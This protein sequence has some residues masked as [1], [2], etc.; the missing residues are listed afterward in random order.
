MARCTTFS[1][2]HWPRGKATGCSTS[3]ARF[4]GVQYPPLL[5]AVV[6]VH[7]LVLGTS[8]PTTVGRWLRLSSFLIFVLYGLVALWFLR[9]YLPP[10]RA[11]LATL[12]SVFCRHAWFL[13]DAL[14]PEV[15]FGVTT[16]LF[17]IFARGAG[18]RARGIVAYVW[19]LASYAL[20][21]VGIAAF[22]VWVL[23]SLIR[24]RFREAA[25]RA[26]L[27]LLPVAGW[28]GYVAS[29]ERS[30]V[31]TRPTYAYQ[32]AP[33]LF[34][35]VSYARNVVLR[36]PFTPEKGKVQLPR[37]IVRNALDLPVHFGETL[38]ASPGYFQM[39]LHWAFGD[40]PM[41]N[42]LIDWGVFALLSA[43]GGVLVTGGVLLLLIRRQPLVPLYVLVYTAAM[44]LTPFPGQ[45]ARYLMPIAPLL[46]LLAIV[47]LDAAASWRRPPARE[48][49]AG[50]P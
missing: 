16:L 34:Y 20:R 49:G 43:C 29:V 9:L 37:R 10:G 24:R 17:L 31:Y 36:D 39:C 48:P 1:A 15:W 45:Y 41:M 47:C 13:S 33:Y 18:D 25:I 12:L 23:D 19:A 22:A 21:T 2:R 8:D 3:R 42:R 30:D 26:V 44:C 40:G 50:S 28:H 7:Q 32:R 14:F 6:A 38:S 46:A 35:N 27:V 5:P 11:L 4:E